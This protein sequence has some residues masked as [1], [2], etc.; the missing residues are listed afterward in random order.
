MATTKIEKPG[1][2]TKGNVFEDLGFSSEVS[3]A[4]VLKNEIH[5]NIIKAVKANDL[6]PRAL[7]RI[8]NIQQPRVSELLNGK[9]G[10]CS[11]EKLISY[12]DKLGAT[13]ISLNVKMKKIA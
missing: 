11:I 12:L 5:S 4:E 9:I 7:E 8:L 13:K 2:V 3:A 6:T 1:H 10:S